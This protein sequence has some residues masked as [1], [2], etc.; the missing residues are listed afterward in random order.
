VSK[1]NRRAALKAN[2]AG[3][4]KPAAAGRGRHSRA[5]GFRCCRSHLE[6]A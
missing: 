3:I 2:W 5:P 1:T 6:A 4:S